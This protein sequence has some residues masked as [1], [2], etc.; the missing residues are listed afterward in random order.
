MNLAIS[1]TA[2]K[3]QLFVSIVGFR[4]GRCSLSVASC[5]SPIYQSA[6]FVALRCFSSSIP[7]SFLSASESA[8]SDAGGIEIDTGEQ[9]LF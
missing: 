2:K 7:T 9:L 5:S 6:A 8:K 3:M 4:R 1:F